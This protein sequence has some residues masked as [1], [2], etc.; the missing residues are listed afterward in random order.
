MDE[1]NSKAEARG[2]AA[3]TPPAVNE[4]KSAEHLPDKL[5]AQR[6]EVAE[7]VARDMEELESGWKQPWVQAGAPMNPAT[8]TEYRGGNAVYLKA[9]AAIRGYGDYR[10][11][12]YNQ[13]KERGWKLKKGSKAV[14]VE[15]WRSVAVERKDA[16]GN[17]IAGK[18]GEPERG[19]RLVLDGYWNVFNLSCFEGAPELTSFEPNDDA[20]FG[21]LADELKASCRCPVEETASPDA[22]YSPGAD[23]VTVPKREQF[24]SN[25]AFCGTLLH[26]MAHATAPELGR[27][28][29]NLFGTEAYAREE[30]TAELASLFASGELG[31]PVDPDARGEHYEQHVKYLANWAKAIREDPDA[32][33]R[34]AGAAGKAATYTVDRWEESTGKQAPG[35][36]EARVARTA[37][38]ADR[39]E[40]ER[41]GD[42]K[43]AIEK[44]KEGA[45]TERAERLKRSAERKRQ[46]QAS[47]GPSRRGPSSRDADQSRGRS[48]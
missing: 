19:T 48:R 26:E 23:K 37:Y 32:L 9:Y 10:W 31:V 27:D 13:G 18:D 35:R 24:E 40:K 47:T 20:D 38:E 34:A 42:K 4:P 30:L 29:V 2:Q 3:I 44:Q 43:T 5:V 1:P 14:S 17:A 33:F 12:T 6:R 39:A 7:K 22:F 46:Q 36:A 16:R 28:V 21:L 41:L 15:H 25:A 11:A 8:G 45:R